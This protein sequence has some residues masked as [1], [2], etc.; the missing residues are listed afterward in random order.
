MK[1]ALLVVVLLAGSLAGAY[2]VFETRRERTYRRL[3][4]MDAD[5]ASATSG[6]WA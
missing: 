1:W 2:G 5:F 3:I 4:E 6:L